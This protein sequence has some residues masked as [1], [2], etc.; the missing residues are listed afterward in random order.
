MKKLL[1]TAAFVAAACLNSINAF[2]QDPTPTQ[3]AAA[4]PPAGAK[5]AGPPAAQVLGPDAKAIA[6]AI[7]M[8]QKGSN[9]FG[10]FNA[11]NYSQQYIVAITINR[12][13]GFGMLYGGMYVNDDWVLTF[14]KIDDKLHI[15]RRNVRFKATPGTPESKAVFNAY[16]DSVL[17]SLPII[18]QGPK[19]GDLVD[20]TPVFLGDFAQIAMALPGF[21]PSPQ[22]S[23]VE[24]IKGYDKNV[25]IRI[26]ATYASSGASRI[27]SIADTR[28]ATIGIHYSIAQLPQ[29]SYQPRMADDRVG[30]FMTV[31]KDFNYKGDRDNFVRYI[32]RWNLEKADPTAAVSPPKK[33][34]RFFLDKT[35]PYS[36]RRPIREAIEEWNKAYEK[37][38]FLNA[39]EVDEQREEETWD[40]EDIRYNTFRWITSNAGFAI[41]PSHVNPYTGE[42]LDADIL[43]DADFIQ[44]WQSDIETANPHAAILLAD[45][46][47]M[48]AMSPT[49]EGT[50]KRLLMRRD[51]GECMLGATMAAEMLLGATVLQQPAADPAAAK[52]LFDK[53]VFQGL[54]E[55]AMHEVGHTLGLRHNFKASKL[56]TIK[57][58]NDPAIAK[59]NGI[60]ASVM[61]YTPTNIATKDMLQG[62]FYT[63]TIGAYDYWAIEYG[64]K[65]LSGGTMGELAELKKIA[66]RSGEKALQYATD[67]D[68]T[69]ISPDPDSN[70]FDMGGDPLEFALHRA[71][72]TEEQVPSLVE[73]LVKDGDDYSAAR[74]AFQNLITLQTR[75]MGFAARQVGGIK[76]S[77]SHKGDKDGAPPFSLVDPKLQRDV[78]TMIE[79]KV[80]G[81]K[82]YSLPAETW[83]LLGTTH[84]SHWGQDPPARRDF[85]IHDFVLSQQQ[86]ILSSL[87]SSSNLSRLYDAELKASSDADVV[88][89]AELIQR[90][91]KSIFAEVDTVRGGEFTNRKPAISSLRRNLQRAYFERLADFALRRGGAPADCQSIA[92][93]EMAS[94]RDRID[95]MLKSEA[96]LDPYTRAHLVE[97]QDRI[98]KVLEASITLTGGSGG[99]PIFLR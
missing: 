83:N 26:N 90:L 93:A 27:D 63:P 92:Y 14:R 59:P 82:P 91:T 61:D 98:K 70:R 58:M 65:P 28:G 18:T 49:P 73:R 56:Y 76:T 40:P 53:L 4:Q 34:I 68:T 3:P 43:F 6:G 30:Y 96:K 94:L 24:F 64:Y 97:L 12:G 95:A 62:D 77:R 74:R 41:G 84:W 2:A 36:Y 67:E 8:Y 19:G 99:G 9:I 44:S 10:E 45:E 87:L 54:K 46:A 17:F 47:L 86:S 1:F 51:G 16:T 37:V 80:L 33:P 79:E 48:G 38:G 21:A 50:A 20:L 60:V 32:N 66:S 5:P 31:V 85:G 35:I 71:K 11:S 55:V 42:I 15:I 88:T 69:F 23:T 7:N 81:D 22:K 57:E 75:A 89:A 29:S 39:V 13:I 52:A 72:I 25:E 78:L